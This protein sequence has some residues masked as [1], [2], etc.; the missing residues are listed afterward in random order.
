MKKA[1]VTGGYGFIG[2]AIVKNLLSKNFIVLNID[3]LTYASNLNNIN[4]SE[5]NYRNL[6]FLKKDISD[7]SLEKKIINFNPNFLI[8]AAAETHVDNSI[9]SPNEFINTNI[10]GTFNLIKIAKKIKNKKFKFVQVSTDEVFGDLKRSK[11]KFNVF[12]NYNPSSPYSAS[13]ASADL[14]LKSWFR[15]FDLKGCIAIS[16]N[17]YGPNQDFEKLIPKIIKK[18]MTNQKIPIYNKGKEKRNWLYVEDNAEAIVRVALLGKN[19]RSYLIGS[20]ECFENIYVAKLIC[21]IF[22]RIKPKSKKYENKIVFVKDRLG[23]DFKYDID[24]SATRKELSWKCKK[25]FKENIM[26]TINSY[27]TK[28]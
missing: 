24:N 9:K 27:L 20:N 21:R 17:N 23:H 19:K 22:D 28:K 16:S 14:L 8:N 7:P 1:I 2:S 3:K 12:S 4:R 15:T 5:K 6:R 18:C 25:K 10:L 13:K 11:K 26:L